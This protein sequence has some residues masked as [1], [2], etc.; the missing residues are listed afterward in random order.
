MR[1]TSVP[2]RT[3]AH[4]SHIS[5]NRPEFVSN[6][7]ELRTLAPHL[8]FIPVLQGWHLADYVACADRYQQAGVDLRRV[9]LV[10]LGS[11]CRRQATGEVA[12]ITRVLAGE[13]GLPLHAFGVKTRGLAHFAAWLVSA[14]SLAWSYQA[15][16]R[17]PLPGCTTH[18]NCANCPR[19]ALAWHHHIT[20][21]LHARQLRLDELAAWSGGET[22]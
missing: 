11:V 22:P 19:W 16:R 8:P 12:H 20:A 3:E 6:Y 13:R 5:C 10:G 7:L 17:P 1:L 14:D 18:R 2:G 4:E 21:S 15:R 9:P